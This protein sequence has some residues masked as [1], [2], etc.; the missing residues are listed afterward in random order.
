MGTNYI[1]TKLDIHVDY[2]STFPKP[3][4]TAAILSVITACY[5]I[6]YV[7]LS[8][9]CRNPKISFFATMVM[10]N[11]CVYIL[12][13]IGVSKIPNNE[14]F[15]NTE[16]IWKEGEMKERGPIGQFFM[17][18]NERSNKILDFGPYLSKLIP[19]QAVKML[20]DVGT[21]RIALAIIGI[22][23]YIFNIFVSLFIWWK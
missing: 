8:S 7:C 12:S 21:W 17:W 13:A 4:D 19:C 14:E 5:S 20:Q 22:G 1:N 11:S 10:L 23:G 15:C 9:C 18:W 3:L 16:S 2:L 6:F